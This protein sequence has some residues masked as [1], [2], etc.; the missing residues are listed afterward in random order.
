MTLAVELELTQ[1]EAAAL[2]AAEVV[3]EKGIK[4]FVAVGTA[5]A[6]IRDR[7]LY[8]TTYTS[9]ELYCTQRW[10]LSRSYAHRVIEAAQVVEM[11]PTGN[12]AP[13]SERQAR[14]LT[15]LR[16][17]PEA[18]AAAWSDAVENAHGGQPTAAE[19]RDAVRRLNEISDEVAKARPTSRSAPSPTSGSA[20]P[21]PARRRP[22]PDALREVVYELRKAAERLERLAHDDRFPSYAEQFFTSYDADLATVEGVI[23]EL[24]AHRRAGGR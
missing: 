11:L 9:F 20:P 2:D 15:P 1:G 7:R 22:L 12:T 5:L 8:R 14:E 16:D 4:T 6:E 18:L 23:G 13:T 17:D 21:R 3:I 10:G 19:V 24:S